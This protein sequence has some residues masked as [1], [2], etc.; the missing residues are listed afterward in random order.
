MLKEPLP[1]GRRGLKR[2]RGGEERLW[3]IL[4][5]ARGVVLVEGPDRATDL[6]IRI[7]RTMACIWSIVSEGSE[8]QLISIVSEL[9]S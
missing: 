6:P 1:P 9:L 3:H 7:P 4:C 2:P 8:V 5:F